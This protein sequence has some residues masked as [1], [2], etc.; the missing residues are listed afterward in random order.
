MRAVQGSSRAVMQQRSFPVGID[1]RIK[2][3][4]NKSASEGQRGKTRPAQVARPVQ[5]VGTVPAVKSAG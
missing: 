3:R 5:A 4:V 2:I 1:R